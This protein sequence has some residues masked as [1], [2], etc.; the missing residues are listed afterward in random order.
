M[1][2]TNLSSTDGEAA[3]TIYETDGDTETVTV[4]VEANNMFVASN[5][6]LMDAFGE[7]IGDARAYFTVR[8]DFNADGFLFIGNDGKSEAMG[9]LPRN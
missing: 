2:I 3:V 5:V 7:G 8:T 6:D 4:P 9:Y 1:V